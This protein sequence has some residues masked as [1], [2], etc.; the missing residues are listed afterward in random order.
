MRIEELQNLR[1]GKLIGR[2]IHYFPATDS[3]NRRAHDYAERGAKEGTVVLADCQYQGRGRLGR[4]WQSP[5]GLNIYVS[6]ILRPPIP[7]AIAPQITLL[8]GVAAANALAR[9][10][11]LDTRI[12]WP[13]D[14]F[15]Y[16]KKVAG[17][18]SEME[19]VDARIRFVILG[20]GVNV[21]W[22]RKDIPPDLREMATSL[23]AEG[24]AEIPRTRVAAEIFE[25]LEREYTLFLQEGFSPRLRGEW[26]R[27]S[28]IN[29]KQV[30]VTL[31]DKEISGEVLGLD[32]DGA[33]LLLD[34]QGETHRLIVG[35][36]S[37]RL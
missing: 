6:I 13:N 2:E 18:L 29:G 25:E 33:L 10:S 23:R 16:G 30:T 32:T 15:L 8:A 17:I 31:P 35:D 5:A 34:R 3:T 12:K 37:L 22:P 36:I 1:Q 21:N 24:K 11:G 4:S 28:W 7:P 26:N 27:L 9:A 19:A 14:I 20:V